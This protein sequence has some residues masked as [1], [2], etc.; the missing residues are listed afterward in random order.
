MITQT[1]AITGIEITST[2]HNGKVLS[3]TLKKMEC[4]CEEYDCMY[5]IKDKVTKDKMKRGE[6]NVPSV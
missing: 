6:W 2:I 5:C 4:P 3:R 1:L